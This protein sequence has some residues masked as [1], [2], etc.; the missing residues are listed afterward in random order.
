MT[1]LKNKFCSRPWDF[2]EIQEKNI[3]NCCP[4]WVNHV[5]IG[6]TSTD[7]NIEKVWNGVLAK[8]FRKSILDGSFRFCNKELCPQIKNNSLPTLQEVKKGKIGSIYST[9]VEYKLI[10]A[11]KPS[12]INLCYDRSCNLRCPSC[13]KD[14]IYY[15]EDKHKEKFDKLT[16]IN[17]AVLNYVHSDKKPIT[18]NITGSGDPFGSKHFY[19]LL[20]QLNYNKNPKIKL[21]LQ[22]NGVLFEE[23]RWKELKNI[24]KFHIDTIISLDAGDEQ[25]YN[26]TRKGGDWNKVN[27]NLSFIKKLQEEKFINWVR[28]DMVVQK[29]NYKTIPQFINI[30]K[31]YNFHSYTSRIVNWGTF[32][33]IEFY[34]HN[35]FNKQHPEYQEFIDVVKNTP[36]YELH[37]WGNMSEL[38]S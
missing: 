22:T 29:N 15:T 32:T 7:L 14:F 25:A 24:H 18:L 33:P 2:F 16:L 34:N 37:D 1:D 8:K 26:L 5:C 9:I 10:Q 20:K 17:E 6:E 19:N 38:T 31:Q 35:I 23:K 13:R 30:A 3:Y 12:T 28:L 36:H 27:R 4:T 21:L 11:D